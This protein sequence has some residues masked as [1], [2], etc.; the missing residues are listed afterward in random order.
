L[1]FE[2]LYNEDY[3]RAK[4]A[5]PLTDYMF[6]LEH[7][8]AS[9]RI[10]ELRGIVEAVSSVTGSLAGKSWLD[11]GCGNGGLIRHLTAVAPEAKLTAGFEEGW[12]AYEARRNH[13]NVL[14]ESELGKLSGSFDVVSAVEVLE[15]VLDPVETLSRIKKL[16]KPGGLFFYT[17][18][19]SGPFRRNLL[20]WSYIVP[21]IHVGFFNLKSMSVALERAA[22]EVQH[23]RYLPGF[24]KIIRFKILK[25]LGATRDSPLFN[26]VPWSVVSKLV[27]MK[28]RMSQLPMARAR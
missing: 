14:S 1:D 4:G 20:K 15:H 9:I 18:G 23:G 25:N 22:F 3:Y 10:H 8:E 13:I 12:I 19:N 21:E 24:E 16:L 11:F 26:L 28:Y 17:T 5:D 27:D 7:P 6:E 2:R